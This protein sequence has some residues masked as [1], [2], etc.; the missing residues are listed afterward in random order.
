MLSKSKNPFSFMRFNT[1]AV[2]LT[3]WNTK[4][5]QRGILK[6]I[7]IKKSHLG[8]IQMGVFFRR[9]DSFCLFFSYNKHKS[10]IYKQG[11]KKK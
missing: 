5:S 8:C 10:N 7:Q 1:D 6:V 2:G 9:E 4:K 11:T 3:H